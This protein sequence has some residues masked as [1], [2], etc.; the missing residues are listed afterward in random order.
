MVQNP[1]GVHPLEP[2]QKKAVRNP[3]PARAV[4]HS[5]AYSSGIPAS[6]HAATS[7][8]T[9]IQNCEYSR[10]WLVSQRSGRM[11]PQ[12][13]ES[14]CLQGNDTAIHIRRHVILRLTHVC[15]TVTT[16]INRCG[17]LFQPDGWIK[18]TPVT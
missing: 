5:A 10:G 2:R 3:G 1:G 4:P 18:Q 8:R 7:F 9:A 12:F 17:G 11:R 6:I 16:L 13:G 14:A 15:G